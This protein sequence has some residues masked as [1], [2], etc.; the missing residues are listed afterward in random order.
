MA[1]K[2]MLELSLSERLNVLNYLY[3][4]R[5]KIIVTY[6]RQYML[7]VL[8]KYSEKGFSKYLCILS[9]WIIMLLVT[10]ELNLIILVQIFTAVVRKQEYWSTSSG[11]LALHPSALYLDYTKNVWSLEFF[12]LEFTFTTKKTP[13]FHLK[14][15]THASHFPLIPFLS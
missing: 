8:V 10:K 2:H 15:S 7:D 5:L 4:V 14:E 13:Q 1:C 3:D 6:L 12:L 9:V 11:G